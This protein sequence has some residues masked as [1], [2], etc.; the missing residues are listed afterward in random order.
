MVE[1]PAFCSLGAVDQVCQLSTQLA[2][3]SL[4][5]GHLLPQRTHLLDVVP[6]QS[7]VKVTLLHGYW[8]KRRSTLTSLCQALLDG[9]HR[10]SAATH[11]ICR[12]KSV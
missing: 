3:I 8:E 5:R 7:E 11:L 4:Q 6:L 10:M 2:D 12:L 9:C 1:V